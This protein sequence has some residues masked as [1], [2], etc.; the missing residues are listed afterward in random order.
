MSYAHLVEWDGQRWTQLESGDETVAGRFGG[1]GYA[2]DG[3]LW[4]V[5]EGRLSRFADGAWTPV[6][7]ATRGSPVSPAQGGAVWYISR[8]G[9]VAH[10]EP[11]EFGPAFQRDGRNPTDF[12][13]YM[14]VVAPIAEG[15][16]WFVAPGSGQGLVAWHRTPSGWTGPYVVESQRANTGY[17]RAIVPLPDGRFAVSA[18]GGLW[19]GREGEWTRLRDQETAGIAVGKDGTLWFGGRD[20]PGLLSMRET[21]DGWRPGPTSCAAGGGVVAVGPDGTVW[22]A[23]GSPPQSRVVHVVD[24]R[25]EELTPDGGVASDILALGP[26]LEG[27]VAAVLSTRVDGV[28]RTRIVHWD[29]RRWTTL[30][31]VAGSTDNAALAYGADGTL[32]MVLEPGPGAVRRRR[33]DGRDGRQQRGALNRPRWR[34]LVL[35]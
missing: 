33:L 26:D 34:H 19:V 17:P 30:R 6:A 23:P 24:G 31:D 14:A 13:G 22:S 12:D 2:S 15:D 18:E 20:K 28:E 8:D 5:L 21:K 1:I 11:L 3:A 4:A 9:A 7:D 10:T 32:W 29:G 27:G 16:Q 25:C 35:R